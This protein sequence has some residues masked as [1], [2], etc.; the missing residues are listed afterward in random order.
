M[1]I[2]STRARPPILRRAAAGLVLAL[3]AVLA[4]HFVIGLIMAVVYFVAVV[5]VIVAVAWAL[6]TILW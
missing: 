3:A 6:K 1:Q 5:A 4:V 2:E